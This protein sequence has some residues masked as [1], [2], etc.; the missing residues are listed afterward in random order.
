[1]RAGLPLT[2]SCSI[3]W[4]PR[5]FATDIW[6]TQRVGRISRKFVLPA[7]NWRRIIVVS[8]LL[9]PDG[10]GDHV[11]NVRSGVMAEVV[12]QLGMSVFVLILLGVGLYY[13]LRR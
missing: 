8:L 11:L 13:A 1:M 2:N 10:A 7:L 6:H 12:G 3:F 9:Q 4:L 5:A